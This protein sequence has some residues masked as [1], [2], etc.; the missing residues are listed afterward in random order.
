MG[1]L[2]SLPEDVSSIINMIQGFKDENEEDAGA[3]TDVQRA[4]AEGFIAS[5]IGHYVVRRDANEDYPSMHEYFVLQAFLKNCGIEVVDRHVVLTWRLIV[6]KA[7]S[8][9]DRRGV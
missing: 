5:A 6:S 9:I 4:Y 8:E 1:N 2:V 3:F 7:N